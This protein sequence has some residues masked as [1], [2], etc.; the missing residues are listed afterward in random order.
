MAKKKRADLSER[1]RERLR[2]SSEYYNYTTAA[3]FSWRN[4]EDDF[5]SLL[6][7]LNLIL[8]L[9]SSLVG[10]RHGTSRYHKDIL[11][12]SDCVYTDKQGMNECSAFR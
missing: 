11:F 6:F 2:H 4:L 5:D 7:L 9:L 10:R 12:Q 3:S 8:R 1:Q